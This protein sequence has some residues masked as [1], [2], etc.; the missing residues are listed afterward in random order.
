MSE[1]SRIKDMLE[2][3]VLD[4]YDGEADD[5]YDLIPDEDDLNLVRVL[6]MTCQCHLEITK[7]RD[8][9]RFFA[10]LGMFAGGLLKRLGPTL[11]G[12]RL[13]VLARN[14]EIAGECELGP[15]MRQADN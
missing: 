6:T 9:D 10:V 15:P 4:L 2:T 14:A 13:R 5:Q 3:L 12:R 11:R 8:V 1:D 7:H